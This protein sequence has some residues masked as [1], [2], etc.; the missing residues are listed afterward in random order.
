[1]FVLAIN[2]SPHKNGNVAFMLNYIGEKLT[3]LG[4]EFKVVNAMEAV[5]CAKTPFCTACSTPCNR[6]C[7]EGTRLEEAFEDLVKAD[8]VILSSPVYFG[9][10]SAQI[11]AFFDKT[12]DI[13]GKKLLI[14]KPAAAVSVGAS[15]YGG[16][17]TTIKALHDIMLVQGMSIVGDG[18]MQSG[19]GH[20]GVCASLPI[21]EDKFA[22]ERANAL[23]ERILFINNEQ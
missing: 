13:R 9:T 4:L 14:N 7:F 16:Q 5:L 3:D 10:A 8:F 20:H 22:F 1:M 21:K 11:K 23:V 6:S 17:E 18:S 2:G 19:A 15:K 12:R